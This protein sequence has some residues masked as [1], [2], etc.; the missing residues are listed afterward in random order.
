PDGFILLYPQ[1]EAAEPLTPYKKSPQL[2]AIFQETR[3]WLEIVQIEDVGRLNQSISDGY[4]RDEILV[5][6]A[7]HSRRIAEIAHRIAES[8]REGARL[9]LIAGPSSS[10][11]TTFS[12]RLA[13]Q[14]MAHSIQP[15]T[16]E[17]D[18]YFL[19]REKTPRDETGAYDFER[20]QA[21]NRERLND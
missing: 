1:R 15:F 4:I 9:V 17:M 18:N 13:V 5:A 12:K 19:D 14:L 21:L 16:L 2:E 6:E 8:H 7:L 10:G 20:L 11:K 3:D